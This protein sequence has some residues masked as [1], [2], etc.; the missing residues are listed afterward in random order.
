VNIP[1]RLILFALLFIAAPQLP[2]MAQDGTDAPAPDEV[3]AEQPA[4][5]E[6]TGEA[7]EE[8][9]VSDVRPLGQRIWRFLGVFHPA[10][11][12]FPVAL[13][14]ISAVFIVLRWKFKSI[15][16]DVAFYTL[17][18]GAITSIIASAMGW[19]FAPQRAYG[20]MFAGPDAAVF[21]HRWT[22]VL[23]SVI[24]VIV[25][26]MATRARYVNN[27][28]PI[29][30]ERWHMGVLICAILVGLTGHQGGALV[31]GDDFYDKAFRKLLLI[32]PPD[33][34]VVTPIIDPPPQNGDIDFVKHIK[35]IFEAHCVACHGPKTQKAN[36]QLHTKKLAMTSGDMAPYNIVPE[37]AEGSEVYFLVSTDDK[38]SMM[39]PEDEGGPLPTAQIDLIKR[40]INQGADWP[41]DVTLEDKSK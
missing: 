12:H 35:P 4:E 25:A 15:S 29:R 37:D 11:V 39:P 16:P 1:A 9:K 5:P 13:L 26:I 10:F 19:A 40:W 14:T 31:Y 28:D 6:E 30:A 7:A 22:A 23:V 3:V 20:D 33:S 17:W 8:T 38:E 2:V 27:T 34:G 24:A 21:W 32:E 18:A 36:F 41:D